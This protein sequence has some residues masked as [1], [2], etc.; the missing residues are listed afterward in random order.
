MNNYLKLDIYKKNIAES[1]K[2]YIN[3][4]IDRLTLMKDQ[5]PIC[6]DMAKGEY[7]DGL[8]E[9]EQLVTFDNGHTYYWFNDIENYIDENELDE[10]PRFLE[11]WYLSF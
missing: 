3:N 4:K 1:T 8:V 2:F 10:A 9:D 5:D 7:I 6:W 11:S